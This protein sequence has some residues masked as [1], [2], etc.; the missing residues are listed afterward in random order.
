[1]GFPFL[2]GFYSKDLILEFA[3]T[4]FVIDGL[5]IYLLSL[6]SAIFT[7]IYSL[8]LIFFVFSHKKKTN[9]FF[10]YFKFFEKTEVECTW[11]MY[12]S[13]LTLALA[14][15][16]IGF[17]TSD[18]AVGAG[19]FYWN[20][21]IFVLPTHFTYI[22]N[23]FIHPFVKNLPVIVSLTAMYFT[24]FVLNYITMLNKIGYTFLNKYTKF[25]YPT[26]FLLGSFLYHA[27]FFNTLYNCLFL[28]IFTI[29]Y[30]ST[31]KLL[32]KGYF[33]YFGPFGSYK[34]FYYLHYYF[35]N[36]W[37]LVIFFSIFFIFLATC[38]IIA[39]WIIITSSFHLVVLK[40]IGLIP[41]CI[42]LIFIY[43]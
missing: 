39:S 7:A 18:L 26:W 8:R 43:L 27:G 1:M 2:T 28:K 10:T 41:V 31:N 36:S 11:Q 38:V 40:F 16:F 9:A 17:I 22:D 13:M 25:Y 32:D 20:T 15:I 37:V 14:S 35:Q 33:E 42:L 3:Y 24:W 5:F 30:S 12:I 6:L 21:S 19:N 23:E 34:L 29:S 4:R